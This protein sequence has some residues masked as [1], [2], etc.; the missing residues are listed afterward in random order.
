MSQ[1]QTTTDHEVIRQW[2]EERNG[3]PACVEGTGDAD[4]PGLLRIDFEDG[5]PGAEL[6]PLEWDEFF[7]KFDESGLQFLYQ[8]E[9]QD[10]DVSRFCKFINKPR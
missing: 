8:E 5:E 4:D 6:Q 7:E 9:T 10:G 1:S 3:H 2:V